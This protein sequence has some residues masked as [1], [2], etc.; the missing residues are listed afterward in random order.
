MS[1]LNASRAPSLICTALLLP[2]VTG[3]GVIFGGTRETI[4]VQSSPRAA[5]ITTTPPT[6]TYTTPASI[7]LERK[8][9]YNLT[10]TKEGYSSAEF[11]IQN[12]IRVGIVVLDVLFTSL[13]G[14]VIDAVT[15]GWYKLEP[16]T[17]AVALEKLASNIEGP[18]TI[19]V[20]ITV[21]ETDEGKIVRVEPSIP[22]VVTHVEQS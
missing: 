9:S 5:E 4:Q 11:Q 12:R 22:G 20:A 21:E 3:C 7:S 2:L 16:K 18:D 8:H 14:V 17:A 19:Q 15:G 10:F 13:V 6:A 1:S